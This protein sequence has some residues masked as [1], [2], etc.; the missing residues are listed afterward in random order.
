MDVLNI[1]SA[2]VKSDVQT[3]SKFSCVFINDFN[4]LFLVCIIL[5][6][7]VNMLLHIFKLEDESEVISYI[8]AFEI[9]KVMI[10]ST[11]IIVTYIIQ[12]RYLFSAWTFL[13]SL[14][15]SS[16]YYTRFFTQN[17]MENHNL[18]GQQEPRATRRK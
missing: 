12:K 10:N 7:S 3:Q 17:R 15:V 5:G 2:C 4:L 1:N 18:K 13:A 8:V 9:V 6:I 14:K 11:N 16:I